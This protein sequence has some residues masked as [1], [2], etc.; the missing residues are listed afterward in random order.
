MK[1]TAN[2][3]IYS[4]PGRS[5]ILEEVVDFNLADCHHS[6]NLAGFPTPQQPQ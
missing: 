5:K 1:A 2:A 3:G 6:Q 4:I